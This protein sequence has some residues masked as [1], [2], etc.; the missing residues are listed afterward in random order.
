LV[1]VVKMLHNASLLHSDSLVHL[2]RKMK[3]R[4]DVK[5][6]IRNVDLASIVQ[7]DVPALVGYDI[8]THIRHVPCPKCGGRDRFNFRMGNDGVGRV[9]CTHCA[10]SGLDAIAYIRWRDG[11]DFKTACAILT[12]AIA[13]RTQQ[14]VPA[15]I[16]VPAPN[17]SWQIRAR[18]FVDACAEYLWSPQG[19]VALGYLRRRCLTDD[20]IRRYKLGYTPRPRTVDGQ[21]WG[22]DDKTVRAV[23]GITVPR[24]ILGELWAVNVR[25]MNTDGTPYAGSDKYICVTGSVMGLWGADDLKDGSTAIAFG[26]EFDAVLARQSSALPAAVVTF[27]AEGHRPTLQPWGSMLA[28]VHPL[29]VC[30]DND[31]AGDTGAVKW[32]EIPSARRVRVP[33]PY[34][35]LTEYAQAGGD[36]AA[37]IRNWFDA[38]AGPLERLA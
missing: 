15:P 30:M 36:V 19:A 11:V 20:T 18:V 6:F 24:Q 23:A 4:T 35:D 32:A 16:T 14:P 29:L 7:V 1:F 10:P 5:E 12:G 26:G 3:A 25:R 13:P 31:D 34:K 37:L 21:E 2:Y 28:R 17:P 9:Y 27:G 8:T 33:S 38:V 22:L